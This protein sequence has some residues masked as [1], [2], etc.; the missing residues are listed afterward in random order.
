[1]KKSKTLKKEAFTLIELV[2]VIAIIAVL[3]AIA[4]PKYQQSNLS[5]QAAAHNAN[6]RMLKNAGILYLT[7]NPQHTGAISQED[8]APY[9]EEGKFPIPAKIGEGTEPGSFQVTESNGDILV[10]PGSVEIDKTSK[11]LVESAGQ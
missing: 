2:I 3:I 10:Q 5:A 6:V 11:T 7:D 1:M 9:L 4:V 8:L